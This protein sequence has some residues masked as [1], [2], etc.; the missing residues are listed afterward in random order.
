MGNKERT[1]NKS[2][3]VKLKTVYWCDICISLAE[4]VS[5]VYTSWV[6]ILLVSISMQSKSEPMQ[7][8]LINCNRFV[9]KRPQPVRA[10]YHIYD[11]FNVLTILIYSS[12][13]PSQ[14]A[15]TINLKY[16]RLENWWRHQKNH[17]TLVTILVFLKD[18]VEH[19]I[20]AK[21]HTQGLRF[22]MRGPFANPFS[23]VYWM[24]KKIKLSQRL[25]NSCSC[26]TDR[27]ECYKLVTIYI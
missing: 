15:V 22:M 27:S 9:W 10:K 18:L 21:F 23:P 8:R 26:F 14:Y 7:C 3:Q 17:L 20:H 1:C 11:S 12:I 16:N 2:K 13:R 24:S 4:V 25:L 5:N 6:C 19:L